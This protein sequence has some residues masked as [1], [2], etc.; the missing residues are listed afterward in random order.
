[1]D[2]VNINILSGAEG[3]YDVVNINILSGAEGG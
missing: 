3:G 2:L 1:M